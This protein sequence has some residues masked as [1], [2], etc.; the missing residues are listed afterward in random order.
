MAESNLNLALLVEALVFLNSANPQYHGTS[1]TILT[2][3]TAP[4]E[5]Q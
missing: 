1:G 5:R 2:I 3:V 4:D